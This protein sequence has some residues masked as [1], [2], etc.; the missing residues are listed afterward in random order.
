MSPISI[1]APP[2]A[3]PGFDPAS[4]FPPGFLEGF[5]VRDLPGGYLL[6][7]PGQPLD[8]VFIVRSGRVRVY[9]ASEARELSLSILVPGDVF[10]DDVA[11]RRF[12]GANAGSQ[13]VGVDLVDVFGHRLDAR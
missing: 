7:T 8:Q 5:G 4:R 2:S 3:T 9:L 1:A 11:L 12:I 13:Y 6:A 10:V